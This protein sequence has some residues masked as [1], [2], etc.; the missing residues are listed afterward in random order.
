MKTPAVPDITGASALVEWFGFWPTFHDAEIVALHLNRQG[1]SSLTIRTWRM[2]NETYE[3]DGRRFYRTE[4]HALVR[5]DLE[6]I[7]DLELS[8]FSPQNVISELN[9]EK[10]AE[11]IRLTL[12]PCYGLAGHIDASRVSVSVSPWQNDTRTSKP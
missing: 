4:K 7:L 12:S 8:D 9:V 5:F 10:R 6:E 3:Q 1:V 11:S 2:T